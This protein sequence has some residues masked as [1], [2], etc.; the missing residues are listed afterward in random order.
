MKIGEE[1]RQIFQ[2][3]NLKK[4]ESES[5]GARM[6]KCD[7]FMKNGD[8]V[9]STG[10]FPEDSENSISSLSS[11]DMVEDESS[12]TCSSSSSSSNGPLYELSELMNQLPIK[13]GLSKFYQGKSQSFTSLASVK[14]V[15]DLAKKGINPYNC[16][17]KIKSTKSF[18]WGLEGQNGLRAKGTISKK[19]FS[20]RGCFSSSLGKI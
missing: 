4:A 12:A 20:S 16:R 9:I 2:G 6:N 13:R 10:S 11:S 14:S 19:G 15:E 7:V 1:E 8:S 18:G 5:E 17:M 3:M